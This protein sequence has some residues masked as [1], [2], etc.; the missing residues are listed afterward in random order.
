MT[1]DWADRWA[2]LSVSDATRQI[3]ALLAREVTDEGRRGPRFIPVETVLCLAAAEVVDWRRYGGSR[4]PG[5]PK[6]VPE[7]ARLFR[8][9]ES[10]V[11][12]KMANL[13]GSLPNG[14]R[15]DQE[16]RKLLL[17]DGGRD[18]GRTYAVIM[19]AARR[20]GVDEQSLPDFM[21]T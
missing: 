6:P 21:P 2:L 5:A 9:T 17:R 15:F 13:D 7:L 1:L 12:H 18:L 10:S 20:S 16:I 11:L 14:A 4:N 3:E 8:R 19:L